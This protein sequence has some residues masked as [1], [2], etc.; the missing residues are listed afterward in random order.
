MNLS[1]SS[2]GI[3]SYKSGCQ[4]ARIVT[5]RWAS[6]NL[7]CA[8][9]DSERIQ[10]EPP[11]TKATDFR[12][13][14][15][16]HAYQLKAMR[17]WN[18]R[19]VVDAGYDSMVTAIRS[20]T[21]PSLFLLHYAHTWQVTNL[22]LIPHF[23]LTESVIE[24]R[25]P[26]SKLA[27]RAGWVGCNI[28]LSEIPKDGKLRLVHDGFEAEASDVRTKFRRVL[29]FAELEA[30]LRGWTVDVLKIVRKLDKKDFTLSDVYA[31]ESELSNRH[32][33]NR[34]I[35]PKIR[36]QLQV[37]RDVGILEFTKRGLYALRF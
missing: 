8:S 4:I 14:R 30:N 22:V 23:F 15:C 32:P 6:L 26:L 34:N 36:Q 19:K 16:N 11:N 24:K 35:R 28:L 13:C 29:P 1:L 21:R 17:R 3:E 5:E 20:E 2:V 37:L 9:C 31:Y 7:Y 25:P 12:C 33:G 18:E 27:R 10:Q